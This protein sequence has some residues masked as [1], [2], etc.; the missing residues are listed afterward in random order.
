[1]DFYNIIS[2]MRTQFV[3]CEILKHLCFFFNDWTTH[4][5]NY[6]RF[7]VPPLAMFQNELIW[8]NKSFTED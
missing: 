5:H 2:K 7:G 4:K 3:K 1:M 6:T 8:K